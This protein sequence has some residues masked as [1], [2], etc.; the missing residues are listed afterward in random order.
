MYQR[1]QWSKLHPN[2]T[3]VTLPKQKDPN[4]ARFF[5]KSMLKDRFNRTRYRQTKHLSPIDSIEE[6][7]DEKVFPHSSYI[8]CF[9]VDERNPKEQELYIH[10]EKDQEPEIIKELSCKINQIPK[11]S[12]PISYD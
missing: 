4:E 3:T 2:D 7:L 1:F 11:G 5:F 12:V 8:K 9:F 6:V 10:F